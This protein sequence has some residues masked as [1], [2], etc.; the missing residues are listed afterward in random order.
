MVHRQYR[1]NPIPNSQEDDK[2]TATP[3]TMHA[4][5]FHQVDAV[6]LYKMMDATLRVEH[7]VINEPVAFAQTEKQSNLLANTKILS[8]LK[9]RSHISSVITLFD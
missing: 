5:C 7:S 6:S 3:P 8:K 4:H 1:R 9:Q 2:L